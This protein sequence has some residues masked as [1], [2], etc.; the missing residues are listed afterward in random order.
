MQQ[1]E[2]WSERQDLNLRKTPDSVE[3]PNGDTQRDSQT[4]VVLGPERRAKIL[5]AI[6]P[7]PVRLVMSDRSL[8][9]FK[10]W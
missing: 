3:N 4:P 8:V 7:K 5:V 6:R 2:S 10:A 9:S 1:N